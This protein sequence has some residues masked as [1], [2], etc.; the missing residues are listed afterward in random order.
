MTVSS[1]RTPKAC[2]ERAV[3]F[4]KDAEELRAI[5]S[6]WY[7]VSYFYAAFHTVRASLMED[8]VFSDLSRLKSYNEAWIPDDR[9]NEHHQA[10]RGSHGQNPPG[11][12]D[13]VKMLY[14]QIAVEYVQLHSASVAVRYGFG[15][16]A[17]DADALATAFDTIAKAAAAGRLVAT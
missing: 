2:R 9:F 16:A 4:K 12:S 5:S 8:P 13:M 14:P 1:V 10:R 7:A 6:Q 15:L 11:V 17:Y 3:A